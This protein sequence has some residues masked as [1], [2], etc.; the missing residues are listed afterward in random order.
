MLTLL[1]LQPCLLKQHLNTPKKYKE[2]CIKVQSIS[3][4]L[5]ITKVEISFEKTDDATRIEGLC[6]V[7]YMILDLIYVRPPSIHEQR[8]DPSSIGLI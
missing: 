8:E 1:K 5:D 2:L 6:R 7:I 3:S 4:F